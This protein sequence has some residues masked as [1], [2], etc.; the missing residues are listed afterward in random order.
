MDFAVVDEDPPKPAVA[1]HR[2]GLGLTLPLASALYAVERIA[3]PC[4]RVALPTAPCAGRHVTV[5]VATTLKSAPQA[6]RSGDALNWGRSSLCSTRSVAARSRVTAGSPA[7]DNHPP[8][9]LG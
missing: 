3:T 2:H 6:G 4:V 1:V 7:A 8:G 5:V 9:S